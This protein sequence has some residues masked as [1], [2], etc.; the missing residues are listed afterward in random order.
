MQSY[1]DRSVHAIIRSPT[2]MLVKVNAVV[3][4]SQQVD[5]RRFYAMLGPDWLSLLPNQNSQYS[6]YTKKLIEMLRESAGCPVYGHVSP[7]S[8]VGDVMRTLARSE[9]RKEPITFIGNYR[10]PEP[11]IDQQ[12]EQKIGC[13]YMHDI[14][15]GLF[16][17][18]MFTDDKE[19]F[20]STGVL[21][22][23]VPSFSTS[24]W[25][26]LTASLYRKNNFQVDFE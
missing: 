18:A 12:V 23:D 24:E 1:Q 3:K 6:E 11:R 5:D 8:D 4:H 7:Y 2:N 13:L 22:P 26:V 17:K 19:F 15:A 21:L 10:V 16:S 14:Q 9:G 20:S 25:E